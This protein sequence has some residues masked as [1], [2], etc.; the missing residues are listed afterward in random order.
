MKIINKLGLNAAALA[1]VRK[2]IV[3]TRQVEHRNLVRLVDAVETET[4]V[5]VIL[6]YCDGGGG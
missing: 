2:E 6:E 3:L 1:T 4:D 5:F